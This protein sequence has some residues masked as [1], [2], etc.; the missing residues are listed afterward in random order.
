MLA[1][2]KIVVSVVV[3]N[4]SRNNAIFRLQMQTIEKLIISVA[5]YSRALS[6]CM[7]KRQVSSQY[8]ASQGRGCCNALL[9]SLSKL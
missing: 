3:S 6:A 5:A 8:L 1:D 2:P 7:S 9:I 4:K